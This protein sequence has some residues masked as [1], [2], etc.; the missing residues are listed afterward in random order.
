MQFRW[1]ALSQVVRFAVVVK[2]QAHCDM[3]SDIKTSPWPAVTSRE[4][5]QPATAELLHLLRVLSELDFWGVLHNWLR[6]LALEKPLFNV[7]Q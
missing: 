3:F 6:C 5:G 1:V 4:F 2:W 7:S